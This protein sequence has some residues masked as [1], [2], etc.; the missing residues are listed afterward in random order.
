MK[1]G[2]SCADVLPAA[3]GALFPGQADFAVQLLHAGVWKITHA[4]K[5]FHFNQHYAAVYGITRPSP[6]PLAEMIEYWI[7]SGRTNEPGRYQAYLENDDLTG[8]IPDDLAFTQPGGEKIYL[9]NPHRTIFDEAGRIVETVGMVVDVSGTVQEL[10]ELASLQELM[11]KISQDFICAGDFDLQMQNALC[12]L[13]EKF[14]CS[15]IVLAVL[16]D[17]SELVPRYFW[18]DENLSGQ[19]LPRLSLPFAA[20]SAF[21]DSFVTRG[22]PYLV[23]DADARGNY[24]R[25]PLVDELKAAL[26]LPLAVD[27]TVIGM[28]EFSHLARHSWKDTDLQAAQLMA[29]MFSVAFEGRRAETELRAETEKLAVASREAEAGRARQ[30][31]ISQI[32]QFFARDMTE[33]EMFACTLQ[34]TAE[35]LLLNAVYLLKHIPE[36]SAYVV[37]YSEAGPGG[38][39]MAVIGEKVPQVREDSI[40]AKLERGEPWCLYDFSAAPHSTRGFFGPGNSSQKFIAVPVLYKGGPFALICCSSRQPGKWS[41]DDISFLQFVST[42][43]STGLERIYARTNMLEQDRRLQRASEVLN[44]ALDSMDSCV[45][46]SDKDTDELLLVNR[47]MARLFDLHEDVRGRKCWEVF[48][49][50]FSGRCSFCP[51]PKLHAGNPGPL[52]WEEFEPN[53]RAYIRHTDKLIHWPDGRV[54][55]IQSAFDITDL[56]TAEQAAERQVGQQSLMADIATSFISLDDVDAQISDALDRVGAF[57]DCDKILVAQFDADE[58][59]LKTQ[60]SW[61]APG[62]IACP[63]EDVFAFTPGMPDYD[64]LVAHK[65]PYVKYD[66]VRSH[67]ITVVGRTYLFPPGSGYMAA[68]VTPYFIGGEFGGVIKYIKREEVYHWTDSEIQLATLI[69]GVHSV[70]VARNREA[71]NLVKAK[72]DAEAASQAKSMFLSNMSHEIRTPMNAIIGMTQIARG[73]NDANKMNDCIHKIEDSS[74]QLL[75]IIN[76]VLDISKIESGKY[77]L[78]LAPFALEKMLIS[79][80]GFIQDKVESKKIVMDVLFDDCICKTYVGDETRI[81]QALTNLLSNAVKFTPAGGRITVGAKVDGQADGRSALLFSV[82]DTGIGMDE[83]QLSRVFQAF[84]QADGSITRKYGGTGL[85]LP[86]SKSLVEKM[87]GDMRVESTPDKGSV[88]SFRL[89]LEA[90]AGRESA[91]FGLRGMANVLVLDADKTAAGQLAF[92]FKLLGLSADFAQNAAE[93]RRLAKAAEQAGRPYDAAFL[94]FYTPESGAAA[95]FGPQAPPV[96]GGALVAVTPFSSW[97]TRD[98]AVRAGIV[99][100]LTKPLFVT[101]VADVVRG[102]L[103][104]QAS[105]APRHTAEYAAAPDFS[106]L[107]I[108]LAE[109]IEI[110]TEIFIAMLEDTGAQIDAAADGVVA[111]EK[112]NAHPDQYDMIITDIQMPNKNGYDV[113]R[114]VRAAGYANSKTIPI[115]AMTANA[116]REDVEKCLAAGMNDHIEKPVSRESILEKIAKYGC[117]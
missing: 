84:E 99:Q 97:H 32:S 17:A 69:S 21:Y 75:S 53:S 102:I 44:T 11:V 54:V 19:A 92:I 63:W 24:E 6:I 37:Q 60:H 113:A 104:G 10:R 36:E 95:L 82:A 62:S 20:G 58:Q 40:Q 14:D 23:A 30:A 15:R 42:I 55:H 13:G 78:E 116:F 61:Y 51:K 94:D 115:I 41:E 96:L 71:Q 12:M 114:D 66:D 47:A 4:D 56:K 39:P 33:D 76:D 9:K 52:V 2:N 68:L 112:Y 64:A 26:A 38:K 85:G 50:G 86:I 65:L 74:K 110:N 25:V 16:N 18:M 80:C 103:S 29:N 5:L 93:A 117:V 88:F 108:L 27:G 31:A 87:G 106:H 105:A 100:Y 57:L 48:R 91:A 8:I 35:Y 101:P 89:P 98:D 107:R 77:E 3:D 67:S 1:Q 45:Y 70:V 79:T 28:L 49:P 7:S 72:N 59:V 83:E 73:S 34:K 109:D 43:F 22:L 90:A 111:M 46:V 81:A